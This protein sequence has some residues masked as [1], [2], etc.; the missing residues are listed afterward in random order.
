MAFDLHP[1]SQ[2]LHNG[3]RV[4]LRATE[5]PRASGGTQRR[6]VAEVADAVVVLPLIELDG[7]IPGV[8]LIRNERF[9]VGRTLWELPAGTLEPGEDPATCAGRELAEETGY[10][11]DTIE[12]LTAFYPSP[13]FCT[14]KLFAFRATGLTHV[15]QSLDETERITPEPLPL[16]RAYDMIRDGVIEDA[17]TIATLLFHHTFGRSD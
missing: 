15:G 6:E 13:G 5:R 11:A 12:P 9:A 2:L 7:H 10:A 8:V 17:K 1:D 14:E 16:S 4:N 3:V